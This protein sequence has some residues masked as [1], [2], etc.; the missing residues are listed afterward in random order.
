MA[1]V[2]GIVDCVL[3]GDDF[4][5]VSIIEDVTNDLETFLIW[6]SPAEPS[7]FTRVMHSMWISLLRDSLVNGKKVRV[8]TSSS[9]GGLISSVRLN[10]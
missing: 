5:F 10:N 3:I 8:V 9:T 1:T 2:I 4:G 7:A 6:S